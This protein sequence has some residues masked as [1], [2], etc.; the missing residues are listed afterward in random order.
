MMHV[1][2]KKCPCSVSHVPSNYMPHHF[3]VSFSCVLLIATKLY[4][5]CQFKK[6]ILLSLLSRVIIMI[7]VVH[8]HLLYLKT[9][10][11]I[12]SL[13]SCRTTHW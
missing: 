5:A 12:P 7:K 2:L 3:I 8:Y 4:A 6:K 11:C 13:L 9:A 10:T 1:E